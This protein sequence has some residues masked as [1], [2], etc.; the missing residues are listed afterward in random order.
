MVSPS[1][2]GRLWRRQILERGALYFLR[3]C[4]M[5]SSGR[6]FSGTSLLRAILSAG[7][8]LAFV[9]CGDAKN[10]KDI[11]AG[12]EFAVKTCSPCHIVPSQPIQEQPSRP[13]G[14][15]FEEIA[16]GAKAAPE[17]L[18]GFLLSTHSSVSHP[19]AMPNLG[20]TEDQIRLISAYVS[21]FRKAK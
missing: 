7:A 17:A 4:A 16:K 15:S 12:R 3:E 2:D 5:K 8:T 13:S 21:S 18:R 10:A 14:P 6:I 20:L 1:G 9:A 19:G 11:R